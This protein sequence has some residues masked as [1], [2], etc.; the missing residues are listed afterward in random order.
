[1]DGISTYGL[2]VL[3]RFRRS[4]YSEPC[5]GKGS[6]D[7]CWFWC[8]VVLDLAAIGIVIGTRSAGGVGR[9]PASLSS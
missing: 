2:A 7:C 5:E 6:W 4:A 8:A 3:G 1:M 9:R